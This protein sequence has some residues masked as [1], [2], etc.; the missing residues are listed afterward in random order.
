M[1]RGDVQY[2][3]MIAE[4]WGVVNPTIKERIL[5]AWFFSAMRFDKSD[6]SCD[7]KVVILLP[8]VDG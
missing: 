1:K 5:K 8:M 7:T 3:S 6:D 4:R 2:L